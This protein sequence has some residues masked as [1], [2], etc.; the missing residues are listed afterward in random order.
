MTHRI[1]ALLQLSPQ[2]LLALPLLAAAHSIMDVQNATD[3]SR[4]TLK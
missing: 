3:A 4:N 1:R 2:L